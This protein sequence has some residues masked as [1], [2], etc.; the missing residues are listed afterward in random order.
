MLP[1]AAV[2]GPDGLK[3]LYLAILG[4]FLLEFFVVVFGLF[5]DFFFEIFLGCYMAM[6]QNRMGTFPVGSLTSCL[7]GAF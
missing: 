6:G 1:H 2:G 7:K 3:D 4:E 5:G